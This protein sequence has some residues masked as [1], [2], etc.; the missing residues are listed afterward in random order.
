MGD[1]DWRL[2]LRFLLM[3]KDV[4]R[5]LVECES[6]NA[7][8]ISMLKASLCIMNKMLERT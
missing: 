3:S 7:N 6:S 8:G 1:G 2:V 5:L 4:D